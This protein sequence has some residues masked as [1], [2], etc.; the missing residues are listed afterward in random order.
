MHRGTNET[1]GTLGGVDLRVH[2]E[3][4]WEVAQIELVDLPLRPV[5][6]DRAELGNSDALGITRQLEHRLHNLETVRDESQTRLITINQEQDRLRALAN[7]PFA[8]IN[9]LNQ[10]RQRLLQLGDTSSPPASNTFGASR[11]DI[12]E[13]R[14]P[15]KSDIVSPASFT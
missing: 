2:A 4:I 8:N 6:Y 9:A 7:Q 13:S 11:L 12:V 15:P 14:S 1:I 5:T 10:A 3:A